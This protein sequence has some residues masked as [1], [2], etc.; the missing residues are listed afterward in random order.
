[1]FRTR[2]ISGIV[3]VALAIAVILAGK[4]VVFA[5]CAAL[6]F[7][8]LF[9]YYRVVGLEHTSLGRTGYAACAVHYLM[10]A[11]GW[12]RYTSLFIIGALM[13]IMANYVLRFPKYRIEQAT[14][15]FFGVV[16][17]GVMLSYI[18][19]VR[20]M[21]DGKILVWM[22]FLSAWGCDT[23]AYCAGRLFGKHKLAPVLSPKKTIEGAIG[24]TLG[25][26]L[27]G[28]LFGM[29]FREKMDEVLRP[30]LVCAVSCGVGALISQIG[31]LAAS[32]IKRDH[33]V[34][35][36]GNLIPGH[37]GVLDRFDRVIFTAPAVYFAIIFLL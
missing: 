14:N 24:G 35:D 11:T 22:I 13:V 21:Q 27:L 33:D 31:D 5:V 28:F 37:G 19:Y 29:A 12:E 18:Y 34:K 16:Y 1:M 9:E 7:I 8:G 36:Y 23:L 17:P 4:Q 15:A 6:S 30:E 32:G 25:A 20:A 2:L 26:A 10:V 3:L